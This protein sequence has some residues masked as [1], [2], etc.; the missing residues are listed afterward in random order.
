MPIYKDGAGA[1]DLVAAAASLC[2]PHHHG[3]WAAGEPGTAF[4]HSFHRYTIGH[5]SLMEILL[6]VCLQNSAK[7]CCV[8]IMHGCTQMLWS[9]NTDVLMLHTSVINQINYNRA[10]FCIFPETNIKI[11]CDLIGSLLNLPFA[12]CLNS[13]TT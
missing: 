8:D 7:K 11:F 9:S 5:L 4:L 6:F 13:F 10:L 2:H 1:T 12:F 3:E